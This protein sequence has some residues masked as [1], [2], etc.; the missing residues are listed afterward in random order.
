MNKKHRKTL[1]AIFSRPT[2][3]GIKWSDIEALLI[4]LGAGISEGRGS[5]IRIELNGEDAVFH[6]LHPRNETDKGAVASMR[7]FLENAGEKP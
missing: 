6:R 4:S 3:A 1:D 7:R 2:Q 5:R